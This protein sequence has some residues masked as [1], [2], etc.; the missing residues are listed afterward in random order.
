MGRLTNPQ[1]ILKD[2]IKKIFINSNITF[3]APGNI[4]LDAYVELNGEIFY[5]NKKKEVYLQNL[6]IE[7]LVMD[8]IPLKFQNTLRVTIEKIL[9]I[10][11][12][13]YPI[14]T[15]KSNDFKKTMTAMLLKNI[16]VENNFMIITLGI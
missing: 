14:Y 11:L 2:G 1:V 4:S 3:N 8:T 9:P 5:N 13:R 16:K 10:I 15:I 12:N 7:K 6:E